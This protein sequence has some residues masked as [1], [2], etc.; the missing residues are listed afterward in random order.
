MS[1]SIY[2]ANRWK[3]DGLRQRPQAIAWTD[4]YDQLSD[5]TYIPIGKE[6]DDFIILSDHNREE[7]DFSK[8]RLENRQRTISG[9]MRS[10]HIADKENV[11]LS[12]NEFPSRAFSGK[13]TF[14]EETGILET[15]G[16][17]MYTVDGGAAGVDIVN[18]YENHPG[19]FYMLLAY[20]RFDR[21]SNQYNKL[22]RYN[23]AIEIMF[24]S[25]EHSV[26]KRGGSTYDFWNISTTLEEV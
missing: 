10:Y 5:G 16:I 14:N 21:L 7:I 23:V 19:S 2:V 13:P 24:G 3:L 12:W 8:Q 1:N 6:F 15:Q 9:A 11:S 4:D 22:N 26:S 20:D 18:W 25:F 17:T